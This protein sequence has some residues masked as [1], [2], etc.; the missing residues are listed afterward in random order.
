MKL[1]HEKEIYCKEV[2][3]NDIIFCPH[4][5]CEDIRL[6]EVAISKDGYITTISDTGALI[7][8]GSPLNG[9]LM[10]ITYRCNNCWLVWIRRQHMREGKIF[11]EEQEV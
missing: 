4:C 8:K 2:V 9:A 7:T 6:V 3:G 5:S 1:A 11:F 10:N